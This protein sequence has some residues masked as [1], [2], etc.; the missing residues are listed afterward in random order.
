VR[1]LSKHSV[2]S[3]LIE[4]S[5][6]G[7]CVQHPLQTTQQWRE[8]KRFNLRIEDLGQREQD[9][10]EGGVGRVSRGQSQQGRGGGRLERAGQKQEEEGK[11]EKIKE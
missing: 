9:Q 10:S 1:D 6:V 3:P 11:G 7:L 5:S 4:N 2:H 8:R